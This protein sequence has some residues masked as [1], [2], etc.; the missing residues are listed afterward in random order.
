MTSLLA[1]HRAPFRPAPPSADAGAA[2]LDARTATSANLPPL[3]AG[4]CGGLR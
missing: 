2:S 4:L 3:Q 1:S